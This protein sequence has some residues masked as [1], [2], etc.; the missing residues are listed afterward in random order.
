M[1]DG[2]AKISGRALVVDDEATRERFAAILPQSPPA[3]GMALFRADLTD[4]SLARVEGDFMVID[5]WRDGGVPW[6][7]RRQ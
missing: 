6:Q 2:D 4:A 1:V 3:S 7:V 5:I